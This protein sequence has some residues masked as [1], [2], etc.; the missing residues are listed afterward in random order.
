MAIGISPKHSRDLFIPSAERE[1]FLAIIY[2]AAKQTGWNIGFV[3]NNGFVAYSKISF[4]SWGEEITVRVNN[5]IPYLRSECTGI[6][7][8]DLG[9]NKSNI[10]KLIAAYY[11][12][13]NNSTPEEIGVMQSV[14]QSEY[15][16][17][18]TGVLKTSISDKKE[19]IT[20][21]FSIFTPAKG[22]IVTPIIININILVFILMLFAGVGFLFPDIYALLYWGGNYPPYT[23]N[24]QWWRILSSVFVHA[25]ALHLL[26]NMM[27]LLY[28]GLLLE[29][30][31]GTF[32]FAAAYFI[33]GIAASLASLCWHELSV[34][35]GASGAIFGLYGVFFVLLVNKQMDKLI[36]KAILPAVSVF[37]L[38]SL[39]NGLKK[40]SGIDNAAHIGGL[41]SGIITGV[42]FLPGLNNIKTRLT[43]QRVIIALSAIL[44]AVATTIYILLPNDVLKYEKDIKHFS[45]MESWALEV[46]NLPEDTPNEKVMAEIKNRGLYYWKESLKVIDGFKKYSLPDKLKKRNMLLKEYCELRIKAYELLYK[47]FQEQ[48]KKY[49]KEVAGYDKKIKSTL[50]KL[51]SVDY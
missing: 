8:F 3:N 21:F 15:H 6:Q 24:G 31:L 1:P 51:T 7:F 5:E 41:V 16:M 25:G 38:Y 26:F 27:A 49:R 23:L 30:L 14:L 48:T 20:G 35:V 11:H 19:K 18:D 36:R 44:V 32:R 9:K 28:A 50:E 39:L 33:T 43:A 22:Y 37:I 47:G 10:E 13:K 12:L 2:E 29:P 17:D 34:S 40:D 45:V 42:L 46:Y 4:R